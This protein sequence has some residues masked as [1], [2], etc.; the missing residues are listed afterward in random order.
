MNVAG[1]N[2]LHTSGK[3]KVMNTRM[4]TEGFT[5]IEAKR[6]HETLADGDEHPTG[7]DR[8][9]PSFRVF[10]K[11]P[12]RCGWRRVRTEPSNAKQGFKNLSR[13]P[14]VQLI[15]INSALGRLFRR[16]RRPIA[17]G[18]T[19]GAPSPDELRRFVKTCERYGYW[20]ATPEENAS[21]GIPLFMSR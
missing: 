5:H 14:V 9:G 13:D 19:L 10:A 6:D 18:A 12:P 7:W 4:K 3:K 8:L 16:I 11:L 20:V 15:T 21:A 17:R 1:L 2:T